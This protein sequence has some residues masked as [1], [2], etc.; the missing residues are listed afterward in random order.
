MLIRYVYISDI[1][2]ITLVDNFYLFLIND[3]I[4]RNSSYSNI[5]RPNYN[6]K[7]LTGLHFF[8]YKK[9][10]PLPQLKE[11]NINDEEL[12]Y[13]L[14]KAKGI[15]IDYNTTY[16]PLFGIHISPHSPDGRRFGGEGLTK[17]W[18]NYCSSDDFKFIY[19]RLDKYVK[20]KIDV[21]NK[22]FKIK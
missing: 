21:V 14:V 15:R 8:E 17:N 10:Y 7:R 22:I 11:Y 9:H 18:I 5:V 3:M 2:I 1:D 4:K 20:K 19:P 16:R 12:L 13:N 6:P